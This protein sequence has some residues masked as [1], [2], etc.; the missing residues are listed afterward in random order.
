MKGKIDNQEAW[1]WLAAFLPGQSNHSISCLRFKPRLLVCTQM[2]SRY[3]E[4]G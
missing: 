1:W 4:K 3:E 2:M